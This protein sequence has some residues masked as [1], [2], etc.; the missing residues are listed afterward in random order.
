MLDKEFCMWNPHF[1]LEKR[2]KSIFHKNLD[3]FF[4]TYPY[5]HLGNTLLVDDMPYK[6]MF[7]VPYNPI[8]LELFHDHHGE[9]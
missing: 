3:I 7:N 4:S 5:T 2:N 6:S 9:D 1:L 8:F